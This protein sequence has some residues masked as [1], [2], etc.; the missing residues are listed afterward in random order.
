MNDIGFYDLVHVDKKSDPG[1]RQND[2]KQ[3]NGKNKEFLLDRCFWLSLFHVGIVRD[4]MRVGYYTF[5]L[6][7]CLF[8][9]FVTCPQDKRC[10]FYSR[11][12]G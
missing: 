9:L 6:F 5:Y 8:Y 4:G 1:S 10:L 3:G 12:R 11:R 2:E 7:V